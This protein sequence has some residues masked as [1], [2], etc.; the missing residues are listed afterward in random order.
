MSRPRDV[1]GAQYR[2]TIF[3]GITY[4]TDAQI[5]D[6]VQNLKQT[7]TGDNYQMIQQ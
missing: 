7:Y 5:R 3:M 2:E 4:L 6:V 1:E